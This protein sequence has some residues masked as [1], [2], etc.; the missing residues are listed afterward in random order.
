VHLRQGLLA[1]A[2]HQP[3]YEGLTMRLLKNAGLVL[4]DG[5]PT[6]AGKARAAKAMLDE[7]RWTIVR[8]DQSYEAAAILYDGLTD[9]E[10]LLTAD[11]LQDVDARLSKPHGVGA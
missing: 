11:Q 2:Q 5:V 4:A 9:L 3:I 8:G 1:L 7:A 6:D 10:T